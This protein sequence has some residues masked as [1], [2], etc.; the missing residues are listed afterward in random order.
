MGISPGCGVSIDQSI[1]CL[2]S[3]GGVP[4]FNRPALKPKDKS[5]SVIPSDL[6]SSSLPAL[7]FSSPICIKP[8][9]L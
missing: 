5:D 2:F 6:F 4:V 1:V 9:R 7:I 8:F 3:L